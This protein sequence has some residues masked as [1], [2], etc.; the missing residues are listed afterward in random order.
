MNA[1]NRHVW[2]PAIVHEVAVSDCA[3]VVDAV[4]QCVLGHTEFTVHDMT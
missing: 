3:V 1:P 4:V 2:Q